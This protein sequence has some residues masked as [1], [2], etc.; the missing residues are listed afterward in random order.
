MYQTFGIIIII[1]KKKN[2]GTQLQLADKCEKE[3]TKFRHSYV[4]TSQGVDKQVRKPN[5]KQVR[6]SLAHVQMRPLCR[7]YTVRDSHESEICAPLAQLNCEMQIS[8]NYS[9]YTIHESV[10]FMIR[11][12]ICE[13][14]QTTT[15][16]SADS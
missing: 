3:V 12:S 6:R 1:K 7:L 2:S 4:D 13:P 16:R 14:S 8:T 9:L 10:K 15:N 5:I 11:T